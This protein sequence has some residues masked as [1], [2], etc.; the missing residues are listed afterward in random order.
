M[1]FEM[2]VMGLVYDTL[3]FGVGMLDAGWSVQ[4]TCVPWNIIGV[5]VRYSE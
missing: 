2:G 1:S 4:T 5:A 3:A